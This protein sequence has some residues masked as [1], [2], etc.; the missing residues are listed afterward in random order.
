[1]F[2]LANLILLDYSLPQEV[3]WRHA[4]HHFKYLPWGVSLHHLFLLQC[5]F[6]LALTVA[7]VITSC[8]SGMHNAKQF[9]LRNQ[10]VSD[11]GPFESPSVSWRPSP[12]LPPASRWLFYRRQRSADWWCRGSI[13]ESAPNPGNCCLWSYRVSPAPTQQPVALDCFPPLGYI[14]FIET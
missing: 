10:L 7:S 13:V 1:M 5:L 4:A 2:D 3:H 6:L 14:I 12:L 9:F 11:Q 8:Q